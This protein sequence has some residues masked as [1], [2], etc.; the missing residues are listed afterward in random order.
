[1]PRGNPPRDRSHDEETKAKFLE[2]LVDDDCKGFI[3]QALAKLNIPYSWYYEWKTTDPAF[4]EAIDKAQEK[5]VRWVESKL[6]ERMEAGSDSSIQFYL[7]TKGKSYG[8][9]E[10]KKIEADV[11]GSVDVEKELEK[12]AEKIG[13][14]V[15]F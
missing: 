14:D 1:M 6:M 9:Q 12:M 10:T 3:N 8:Y 4:V 15:P 7:K 13:D 5:T 11:K 2:V